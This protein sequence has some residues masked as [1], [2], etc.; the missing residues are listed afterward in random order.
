MVCVAEEPT[1]DRLSAGP[2]RR[3]RRLS[4]SSL[5]WRVFAVN[6]A[7]LIVATVV[8]AV[9]PATVSFPVKRNQALVLA[10]GLLAILAANAVLLRLSLALLRDLAKLMRRIDLL[11]P[12]QRLDVEGALEL[13]AVVGTF[14]QM[15]DRLEFERRS[16]STR[17]VGGLEEEPSRPRSRYARPVTSKLPMPSRTSPLS[18]EV[19]PAP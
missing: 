14:N 2:E 5:F 7:L 18:T 13:R 19:R 6:A 11:R 8:L 9:S 15:L 12:G 16:S 17:V 10:L 1:C 3:G 4:P